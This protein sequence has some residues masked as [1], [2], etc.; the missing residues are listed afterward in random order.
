MQFQVVC[1]S[2]DFGFIPA[3]VMGQSTRDR[4]ENVWQ[5][6]TNYVPGAWTMCAFQQW[7]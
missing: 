1:Q 2:K 5:A 6:G 4:I 3:V 7:R